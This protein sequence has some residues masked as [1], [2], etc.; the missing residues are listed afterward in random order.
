MHIA[1]DHQ[2]FSRQPYGGI[3]RY[4]YCLASQI[5]EGQHHH[6]RV[7]AP[8]FVNHYLTKLPPSIIQ[9][10]FWRKYP[11]VTP[12]IFRYVNTIRARPQ[13]TDWQPD[14]LHE[15][16]FSPIRTGPKGVP[17]V[18]TVYDMIH[19]IF[20]KDFWPWDRTSI[21]K[22]RTVERADQVICISESTRQDLLEMFN[23]PEEK[24]T[25]IHLAYERYEPT[26]K[27]ESQHPKLLESKPF[28]LYVGHRRGYKNFS[29]LLEAIAASP[30]LFNQFD[31]VCFGG[32]EITRGEKRLA[33]RLG[34]Q[35]DIKQYA[36]HDNLLGYLYNTASVFVYPS[37][38]E[39]FGLPPLEAMAHDC[40]VA[41]SNTSSLPEVV[42]DAAE[43]FDPTD[44]DSIRHAME[45]VL[46][47]TERQDEL[48][49]LGRQ[50]L[51]RFSWK[52]CAEQTL[53]TYKQI[54]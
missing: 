26:G 51:V 52:K 6:V 9:G 37:L 45:K 27:I 47:S 14:I 20:P 48:I 53:Q 11:P 42:G 31:I 38:Y 24:V 36:G 22:K 8:T 41:C 23:V 3:P 5:L 39:G 19:E 35:G 15:T 44:I 43:L 46:F 25:T 4:F 1:F 30:Q 33:V 32:G 49:H 13:I 10:K 17:C 21:N 40:P 54:H 28:I 29:R 34:V 12:P 50:R 18:V 7:F 16:Y 2:A